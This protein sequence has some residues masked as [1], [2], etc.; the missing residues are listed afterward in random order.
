MAL[1]EKSW[2]LDQLLNL[3]MAIEIFVT[4][5]LL[6]D[7]GRPLEKSIALVVNSF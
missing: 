3:K 5:Q 1:F 4:D 2:S 7:F 6:V